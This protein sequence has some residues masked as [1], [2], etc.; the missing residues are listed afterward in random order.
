MSQWQE[1]ENADGT[2]TACE[3]LNPHYLHSSEHGDPT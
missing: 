3:W 1:R 2:F